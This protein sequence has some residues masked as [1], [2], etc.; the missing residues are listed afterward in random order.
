MGT[1][2]FAA[3]TGS[4]TITNAEIGAKYNLYKLFDATVAADGSIAY[5]LPSGKDVTNDT[6]FN[7]YFEVKNGNVIAKDTFTTTV[8]ASKEFSTWAASFGTK[9]GEEVTAST[10]TVDFSA[11]PFG[12]YYIASSVGTVLTVDSANPHADVIDKNQTVSFDKN[13]VDGNDLIKMN[14]AGL[15]ID[16]PFDITVTAKNYDATEKIFKYET[17]KW[18][19]LKKKFSGVVTG[20]DRKFLNVH[21]NGFSVRVL[22]TS[23]PSEKLK[24]FVEKN[25][26]E[27]LLWCT[28]EIQG[29]K[30]FMNKIGDLDY[31]TATELVVLRTAEIEVFYEVKSGGSEKK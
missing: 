10:D 6:F 29:V 24:Q 27:L 3:D 5:S 23:I 17:A 20:L 15:N 2:A 18:T 14:E 21:P 13:I 8:V 30:R 7:T 16:V 26:E 4:I 25:Q 9:I 11:I 1:A 19:D 28:E 31:Y 22:T 12:Y